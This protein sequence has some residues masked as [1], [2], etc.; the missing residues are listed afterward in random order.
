MDANNRIMELLNEARAGRISTGEFLKKAEENYGVELPNLTQN[1]L[2]DAADFHYL[3][4]KSGLSFLEYAKSV[5]HI[6]NCL[7]ILDIEHASEKYAQAHGLSG[8]LTV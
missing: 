6:L 8:K 5:M 1:L 4:E 3:M 7:E 2:N